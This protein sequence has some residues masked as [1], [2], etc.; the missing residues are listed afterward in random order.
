MF[1]AL[2]EWAKAN[3]AEAK[4]QSSYE[5][6]GNVVK[7]QDPNKESLL[8]VTHYSMYALVIISYTRIRL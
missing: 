8:K 2:I 3:L 5:I 6:G 1:D 7:I 4:K